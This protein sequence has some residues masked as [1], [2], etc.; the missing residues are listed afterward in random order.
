MSH[1]SDYSLLDIP[2]INALF[3]VCVAGVDS[4]YGSARAAAVPKGY[5]GL[6]RGEVQVRQR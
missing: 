2:Y 5:V 4:G 1:Q 3:S 6:H